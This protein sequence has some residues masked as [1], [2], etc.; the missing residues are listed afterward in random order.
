[1]RAAAPLVQGRS[2]GCVISLH[3][4]GSCSVTSSRIRSCSTGRSVAAAE[5]LEGAEP[6]GLDELEAVLKR[7]CGEPWPGRVRPAAGS[8]SRHSPEGLGLGLYESLELLG[9]D[10]SLARI[11]RAAQVA[12]PA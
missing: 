1:M 5:V 7:L 11:R 9:R 12:S 8:A 3:S 6:G 4:P 2:P 10:E